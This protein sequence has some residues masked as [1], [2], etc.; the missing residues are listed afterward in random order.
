[1]NQVKNIISKYEKMRDIVI[2]LSRVTLGVI[3]IYASYDKII[4]PISFANSIT[5]YH[6]S[7]VQLNNLAALIIPWLEFVVGVCLLFGVF[8]QGSSSLTI[9]LLLWFIFILSQALFRGISI[10]CG[11][12]NL[13]ESSESVKLRADMINRIIQDILLLF[14]AF[15]VKYG[16]KK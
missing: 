10:D 12:F 4:D 14:L 8:I 1:M 6:I 16:K 15:L 9:I 13:G 5:Q 7:P 2:L 3:F 11:C